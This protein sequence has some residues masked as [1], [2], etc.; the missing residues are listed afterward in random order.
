MRC[1]Y[2]FRLLAIVAVGFSGALPMAAH[3]AETIGEVSR[4]YPHS[5]GRVYFRIVG[6]TC[7]T[8]TYW[9]FDLGTDAAD[10]W[11]AMLLSAA[12]NKTPVNVA[13]GNCISTDHQTISYVY[14]D[15]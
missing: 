10:A 13:H 4:L 11:Y 6:D 8:S 3:A 2:L 15:F 9:Y 12:H 14:Q 5:N 7:K 1:N